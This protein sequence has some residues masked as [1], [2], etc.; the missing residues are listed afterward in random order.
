MNSPGP[1]Y[2]RWSWARIAAIA[3]MVVAVIAAA[4][5]AAAPRKHSVFPVYMAGVD[6]WIAGKPVYTARD[7]MD[8]YRYPPPSLPL[9]AV[10]K[11]FGLSLGSA[12]WTLAGAAGLFAATEA[13]RRRVLPDGSS[14]SDGQVAAYRLAVLALAARSLWNAQANAAV[15]AMLAG[16]IALSG[17]RL[18]IGS[19]LFS[20]A[21]FLKP[22]V[23]P[24]IML[25]G[26][27]RIPLAAMTAVTGVVLATALSLSLGSGGAALWMD[28]IEH[29]RASAG[30][31]RVAFRDGWTALVSLDAALGGTIPALDAPYPRWW[32]PVSAAAACL[33][34]AYCV[35]RRKPA[36][37]TEPIA[38]AGLLGTSWLLLMG[39]AIEPP[40][41]LLLGPWAGWALAS[42]AGRPL[43]FAVLACAITSLMLPGSPSRSW[44]AWTPALLPLGA[45]L[46]A[47]WAITTGA[48][49]EHSRDAP[50]C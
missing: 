29:G 32:M 37:A 38:T 24:V 19:L 43:A 15:G 50:A 25:A 28:W 36:P 10:F 12:L 41:Y 35:L 18:L 47:A 23:L 39:P 20:V 49:R 13:L 5:L 45:M 33:A 31:R 9:F 40:T 2:S 30:E 21:L 17:Q 46:T 14:W 7:G 6:D 22:T 27:V 4:K 16:G 11:P 44:L 34:C 48:S 3:W 8:L 42:G 1:G 26:A